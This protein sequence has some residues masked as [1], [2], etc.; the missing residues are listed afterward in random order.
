MKQQ[1]RVAIAAPAP[2]PAP[3]PAAAPIAADV[4]A[5]PDSASAVNDNNSKKANTQE[6]V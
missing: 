4:V 3:A 2:A 5:V 6:V 1:E